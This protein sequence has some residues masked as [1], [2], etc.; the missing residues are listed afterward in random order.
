M[1]LLE[2]VPEAL[3]ASK[4]NDLDLIAVPS[5]SEDWLYVGFV[6]P[7]DSQVSSSAFATD[8]GAIGN[9]GMCALI[10]IA[11]DAE[12]VVGISL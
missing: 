11:V 6:H 4:L 9:G 7:K 5:I 1:V 12:L 2:E 10:A 8:K 3:V